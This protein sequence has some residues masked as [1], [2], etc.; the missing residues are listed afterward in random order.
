M[1]EVLQSYLEIMYYDTVKNANFL[2]LEEMLRDKLIEQFKIAQ[3]EDEKPPCTKE[4]LQ[5]FFQDGVDILDFFRKKRGD[6]FQKR[7]YELIGCEVPIEVM[8][9][10]DIKMM[11]RILS[12]YIIIQNLKQFRKKKIILME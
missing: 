1:H 6:Y 9:K 3:E 4:D 12:G 2:N 7:Q 10:K 8:M 11:S 5:E